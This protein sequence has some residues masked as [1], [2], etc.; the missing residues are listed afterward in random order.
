M[1]HFVKSF[2]DASYSI[3]ILRLV[4]AAVFLAHGSQKVLGIFGG[5]G[6]A[7]TT[8]FFV[9]KLHIPVFL[10]YVASFTEFLGGFSMLLGIVTRVFAAGLAIDM[11]VAILAVHLKNG[12][13]GPT[14][15]EF[16]LVLLVIAVAVFLLGPG[17]LSVDAQL[18]PKD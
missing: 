5:Y 16:P 17:K 18:F 4:L 2:A 1:K 10:A 11:A 13:F 7:V 3:F 9:S 6:L 14:G 15:F 8:Q 12:F